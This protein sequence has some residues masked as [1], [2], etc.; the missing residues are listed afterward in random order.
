M[1]FRIELE[2]ES[3]R[4]RITTSGPMGAREFRQLTQEGLAAA[5]AAGLHRVLVDHRAM[6]PAV[7]AVDIHDLP[8]VFVELGITADLR[9][10]TIVPPQHRALFDY[11]QA[12]AW[13]RGDHHFRQFD[14]EA[15]ACAWLAGN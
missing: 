3:E 8:R 14:D 5:R 11:F 4:V 15:E 10:A 13:N 6:V 1:A 7:A 2:P 12:L 9:I